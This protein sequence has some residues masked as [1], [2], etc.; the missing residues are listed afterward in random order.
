MNVFEQYSEKELR[1]YQEAIEI[2]ILSRKAIPYTHFYPNDGEYYVIDSP[3]C[4]SP[5]GE[6]LTDIGQR[7]NVKRNYYLNRYG[8]DISWR[9]VV[10]NGKYL[11]INGR[12]IYK[13]KV[14]V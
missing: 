8:I 5:T 10:M 3:N 13:I 7:L 4:Y 1:A 2:E 6:F 9:I 11:K 12:Y 14:K